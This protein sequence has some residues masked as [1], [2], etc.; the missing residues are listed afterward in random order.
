LKSEK[1]SLAFDK[2][3]QYLV[4]SGLIKKNKK[5]RID[6][7]HIIADVKELGRLELLTETIRLFCTDIIPYM[8]YFDSK[9]EDLVA[10][11]FEKMSIRG[12]SDAIRDQMILDA[13]RAMRVFIE[14]PKCFKQGKDIFGLE[15]YQTLKLVLEQ[16]FLE[17]NNIG[18]CE[19]IKVA[20]GK[21]HICSPHEADAE[22]ANKGGKGWLGY[23]TQVV[24]TVSGTEDINFITH[25]EINT[26][27]T[28]DSEV[29]GPIIE[30]LKSK[31]I[32][33]TK[34]YG[35]T[36]YNSQ[37]NIEEASK[38]SIEL[39]GPVAP[40][41]KKEKLEKNKGF[42]FDEWKKVVIC[43]MKV[44]SRKCIMRPGDGE[45]IAATFPQSECVTCT[46]KNIC[47]PEVRGKRI[48]FRKVSKILTERRKQM[49]TEA[50]K[51]DMHH[52]NGIEGTLSGL[53]RGQ[54]LRRMRYRGIAKASLQVKFCGAAANISRL[55]RHNQIMSATKAA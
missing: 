51:K 22:Y 38:Q 16:N 28:H 42:E 11:Y 4:A 53:V 47:Q 39:K 36:H 25:I 27:T 46:R 54:G 34:L 12:I 24:E 44:C 19:L 18:T 9:L 26:A 7:T 10:C 17:N 3:V 8:E 1:S 55:H 40:L 35:D 33:P 43:P 6:S 48:V 45:H 37:D 50:F 52:R 2:I 14:W 41:P 49:E 32:V 31:E 29:V 20:T 30:E 13:G 5:Q 15:S 23:K 21:D